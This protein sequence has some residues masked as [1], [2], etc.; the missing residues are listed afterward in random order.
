[1]HFFIISQIVI[2]VLEAVIDSSLL[3]IR[4]CLFKCDYISA[5]GLYQEKTCTLK[6]ITYSLIHYFLL[7]YNS[8]MTLLWFHNLFNVQ[9]I[10]PY[11]AN[12]N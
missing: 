12:R 1:M 10:H 5:R 3:Y 8:D 11:L 2:V 4:N 6:W 7:V 9:E